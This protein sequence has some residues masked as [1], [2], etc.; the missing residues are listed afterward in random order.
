MLE[1]TN[2]PNNSDFESLRSSTHICMGRP[3]SPEAFKTLIE[4]TSNPS[5]FLDGIT[6]VK[7]Q[8]QLFD[9]EMYQGLKDL[10]SESAALIIKANQE[11]DATELKAKC[12]ATLADD[13]SNFLL[14][15]KSAVRQI[16]TDQGRDV[17]NHYNN[18][19]KI[20]NILSFFVAKD[21]IPYK[22]DIYE[23]VRGIT[24][25]GHCET[26]SND[27]KYTT[28]SPHLLR[29]TLEYIVQA[30]DSFLQ[31]LQKKTISR[32]TIFDALGNDDDFTLTS[33]VED[34]DFK[35]IQDGYNVTIKWD[36]PILLRNSIEKNQKLFDILQAQK[37]FQ[38]LGGDITTNINRDEISVTLHL[39]HQETTSDENELLKTYFNFI[40]D[41]EVAVTINPT[42]L[43]FNLPH[44]DSDPEN[45]YQIALDPR[46]LRSKESKEGVLAALRLSHILDSNC[47]I[48]SMTTSTDNSGDTSSINFSSPFINGQAGNSFSTLRINNQ[49]LRYR[50]IPDIICD[51][52][53]STNC[54]GL[55]ITDHSPADALFKLQKLQSLVKKA[56]S[57]T[58][59]KLTLLLVE[60]DNATAIVKIHD[61]DGN[62]LV[63]AIYMPD[64]GYFVGRCSKAK[65]IN[66]MVHAFDRVFKYDQ[67]EP[68][69][70]SSMTG[71]INE[72]ST[73]FRKFN[74]NNIFPTEAFKKYLEFRYMLF[75]DSDEAPQQL[76]LSIRNYIK[77][78][79]VT[80]EKIGDGI[81]LDCLLKNDFNEFA[82][83]NMIYLDD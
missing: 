6:K 20:V 41:G 61:S 57:L 16:E 21:N 4:I 83:S 50:N 43:T 47:S 65:R 14:N 56:Q 59:D 29:A 48:S 15:Y 51:L 53:S 46:C 24:P 68:E 40:S 11:P 76:F 12:L 60:D 33:L 71:D 67:N 38:E 44:N 36:N 81:T 32:D 2:D 82:A 45:C 17:D 9:D 5:D 3:I 30:K 54:T 10:T 39:P 27:L 23:A 74:R 79:M 70:P 66:R 35:I 52:T 13:M 25:K 8:L 42:P 73:L 75:A 78:G 80:F 18:I 22:T 77:N 37:L 7:D 26:S 58:D 19:N 55:I 49:A 72:I 62:L 1:P 28:I 69:K 31:K 63:N 34:N 64:G